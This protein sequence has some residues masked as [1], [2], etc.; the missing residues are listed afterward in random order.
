MISTHANMANLLMLSK[1]SLDYGQFRALKQ[2]DFTLGYSEIHAIVGEHGAGKSSL[3]MILAGH[4]K[5]Q[6]GIIRFD[7]KEYHTLTL[8]MARQLKIA[9]IHQH[10][11]SLNK[12]FTVAENLFLTTG[13]FVEGLK[14]KYE[15][16]LKAREYL[17]QHDIDLDPMT[18]V[19][20]LNL[21]DRILLD[22]LKHL[23]TPPRLLILDEAL[24]KLSTVSLKKV[25]SML[26]ALRNAGMS[27]LLITHRLDDIYNLADRVSILRNGEI[28]LTDE[29][30]N[31]DK[32]N[33][34]KMAYMQLSDA[35][36]VEDFHQ[37][38]NQF[39]KYNEA[40]LRSLPANL[41]VTD[42][43]CRVKMINDYCKQSFRLEKPSYFNVPL[44]QLLSST[45]SEVLEAVRSPGA[46]NDVKTLYQVPIS[47]NAL[48]IV[49]NF[50]TFPIYDGTFFI[51]MIILLEDMTEYVQ[52]QKQV[53]L[54]EKL[55][56]V[57]L[58]A[59]GVAH[60]INNPLE[61]I[62]TYMSFMK[63][64]FPTPDFHEA[65]D[66]LQEQISHITNI[67]SNL[68]SFSEKNTLVNED[69]DINDEIR[70]VLKLVRHNAGYKHI[71][72]H[73]EPHQEDL[74]IRANKHEIKQ[75]IL[76]LLKNSFE[77]MPSGGQI[78]IDTA[79]IEADSSNSVQ[80]RFKDTGPGI[81]DEN[82][83]NIFLP[84]YSTKQGA[85]DNLGLG[86]SVSYG[87]IQKYH[88]TITAEN[89]ESGCQFVITLPQAM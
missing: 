42:T 87:I 59:A 77:A 74:L 21:S 13:P 69:L 6:S 86:L 50:K 14:W 7:W 61:I 89:I 35:D 65:L 1:I 30:K 43:E 71:K 38:F 11:L 18:P 32:F 78:F 28:L 51:G 39:L 80:I 10:T 33:L 36:Q 56:S 34:I 49:C 27:I 29:V 55:A 5:P 76:N 57:G 64:K 40:I 48:Q 23:Y 20:E 25:V 75:V 9:I 88:G 85:K 45:N 73:F 8:N 15:T 67:V 19:A 16:I 41:I 63:H 66:T 82:P 44:E 68:L 60:E 31:I 2:I 53:I 24:E 52:L 81:G 12:R 62:Y 54:S 22:I 4:L 79:L 47:F 84:F 37:E 72:L 58:L 3:A 70:V 17:E 26:M 46:K 83:N